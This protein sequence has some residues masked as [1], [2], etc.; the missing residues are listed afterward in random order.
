MP[1]DSDGTGD[2]VLRYLLNQPV[3]RLTDLIHGLRAAHFETY[4]HTVLN[5]V[6]ASERDDHIIAK[7]VAFLFATNEADTGKAVLGTAL[8]GRSNTD[9]TNMIAVLR[10]QNQPESLTAAAEWIKDT[11]ARIGSSN[12]DGIL[13]QVGL[14]EHTSH[15]T[16]LKRRRKNN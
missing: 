12:V 11:H 6:A 5:K 3:T 2:P 1:T 10:Q 14:N 13:R 16:W 7:D 4:A 8:H 9:L 15:G